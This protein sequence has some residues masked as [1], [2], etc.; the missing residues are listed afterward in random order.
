M[1]V[2]N[3]FMFFDE[4]SVRETRNAELTNYPNTGGP[5]VCLARSCGRP[6]TKV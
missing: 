1:S 3:Y 4:E 5:L 2:Q 6:D